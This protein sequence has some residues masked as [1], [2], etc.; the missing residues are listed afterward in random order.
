MIVR[1]FGVGVLLLMAT[2]NPAEAPEVGGWNLPFIYDGFQKH[3]KRWL[4][5][6]SEPSTLGFFWFCGNRW[7]V[8]DHIRPPK[9]GKHSGLYLFFFVVLPIGWIYVIKTYLPS[10]TRT[11]AFPN[12]SRVC[13]SGIRIT[14][15][16]WWWQS[17][18][19]THLA[20]G[21]F[22]PAPWRN[23]TS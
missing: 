21:I 12:M 8:P 6:I 20:G 15:T 10:I 11:Q 2:R 5:Q 13:F 1:L 22:P 9:E 17:P 3:P 14:V 16:G 18:P 19:P 4:V 23:T 7:W